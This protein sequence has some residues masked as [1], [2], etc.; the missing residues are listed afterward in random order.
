[1]NSQVRCYELPE[2]TKLN[3]LIKSVMSDLKT[4]ESYFKC[5]ML[6][7]VTHETLGETIIKQRIIQKKNISSGRILPELGPCDPTHK[8]IAWANICAHTG[9]EPQERSWYKRHAEVIDTPPVPNPRLQRRTRAV[10][11]PGCIYFPPPLLVA[12][13]H[14]IAGPSLWQ[15]ARQ[16]AVIHLLGSR[17]ARQMRILFLE[18]KQGWRAAKLRASLT[19]ELLTAVQHTSL[20]TSI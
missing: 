10:L 5:I 1:M 16:F 11:P 12:Y 20:L 2:Y 18:H 13:G 8:P 6:L 3:Y 4:D 15:T 9:A 17:A 7:T 19:R 14:Q